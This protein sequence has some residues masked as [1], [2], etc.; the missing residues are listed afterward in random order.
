ME[1]DYLK[2]FSIRF[3]T[4]VEFGWEIS[5]S[6]GD[7]I[8][9]VGNHILFVTQENLLYLFTTRDILKSLNDTGKTIRIYTDVQSEPD[10]ASV[11]LAGS[12]LR[13]EQIDLIIAVGGGSVIDVAK[14]LSVSISISKPVWEYVGYTGKQPF[15]IESPLTPVVAIPTT[16]GTGSEVTPYAVLYHRELQRK[17]TIVSPHLTPLVAIV[18]PSLTSSLPQAIT[19]YTGA[20]ALSHAIES[21]LNV[22][23]RTPLSAM[24]SIEAIQ[25]A[26]KALVNA[27][28]N[29]SDHTARSLMS[30][31][32]LLSG[33]SISITGT[34]LSHAM[35][36][37][38]GGLTHMAH[39]LTVAAILPAVLKLFE[40]DYSLS[41][42]TLRKALG[43]DDTP[44]YQQVNHMWRAAGLP[45]S[46]QDLGIDKSYQLKIRQAT[47]TNAG[48]AM[49]PNPIPL[50]A[51]DVDKILAYLW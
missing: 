16:S 27:V 42:D 28:T 39:G 15:P 31:A 38:L 14:A 37:V 20:D 13:K 1:I 34:G 26:S 44:A 45:L 33:L 5:K 49:S 8:P 41:L 11:D 25:A 23:N 4:K 7:L 18:D 32:S 51:K 35:A 19:A 22:P 2:P 12:Y 43:D 21:Y 36:E 9:N 10:S 6:A 3:P 30:W 17:A 46:V 24:L 40:E 29:G 50:G 47:L 48:W